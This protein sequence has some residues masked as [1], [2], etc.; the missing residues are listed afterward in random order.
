MAGVG[1]EHDPAALGPDAHALHPRGMAADLVQADAGRDFGLAVDEIHPPI[2]H[3]PY[4]AADL[5]GLV[6]MAELPIAHVASSRVRHLRSL[7]VKARLGKRVEG[8][9]VVV[10]HVR[11]H[12]FAHVGCLQAHH[13]QALGR[14]AQQRACALRC[15]RRI[16]TGIDHDAALGIAYQPDEIIHVHGRIVRIAADEVCRTIDAAH[17]VSDRVDLIGHRH[18]SCLL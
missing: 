15:H 9:D 14:C 1:G 6:A 3:Q 11:E 16:E 4:H 10:M 5:I 18:A 8:A 7:Q 12:D 2:E 17:G 13:R